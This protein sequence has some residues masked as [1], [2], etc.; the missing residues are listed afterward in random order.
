MNKN[1]KESNECCAKCR[2][3]RCHSYKHENRKITQYFCHRNP[4]TPDNMGSAVFPKVKS[5]HWCGEF[6]P[7]I[8]QE[9][10]GK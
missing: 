9:K 7:E 10:M 5:W 1:N 6:K 3:V 4:P 2:F 8:N